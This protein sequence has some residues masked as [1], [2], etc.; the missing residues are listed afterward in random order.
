MN[1]NI[2]ILF[3]AVETG[4]LEQVRE[5]LDDPAFEVNINL[6]AFTLDQID[7]G[8]VLRQA[9][10]KGYNEIVK[11]LIQHDADVFIKDGFGWTVLHDAVHMNRFDVAKTLIDHGA[12]VNADLADPDVN[13]TPLMVAAGVIGE[14]PCQREMFELLTNAGA[15][16]DFVNQRGKTALHM[17]CRSA[18]TVAVQF[19]IGKGAA[20]TLKDRD[21][22][23]P[24]H[25]ACTNYNTATCRRWANRTD[26]DDT[27]HFWGYSEAD[28]S[29]DMTPI[30]GLLL[31]N[32][33][34][35]NATGHFFTTPL[36]LAIQSKNV[37]RVRLL[38]D[39]GADL[40]SR[41]G[42][43]NRNCLDGCD[44]NHCVPGCTSG[45]KLGESILE[46]A[47]NTTR[48]DMRPILDMIK[49]E[50]DRRRYENLLRSREAIMMGLHERLG[51]NSALCNLDPEL[52]RSLVDEILS[53]DS[54]SL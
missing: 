8:T 16:V 10:S 12:Y 51:E 20:L 49:N 28:N 14:L 34:D 50:P 24:I 38:L 6:S 3:A 35:V 4:N 1:N 27:M 39:R 32:G 37:F 21:R 9:C 11:L 45:R 26:I 18:H 13:E 53:L 19:L 17:A 42:S 25:Y 47:S 22:M 29:A 33:V 52:L 54:I 44:R 36:F 23:Q 2:N 48:G 15:V 40:Y 46:C 7:R 43:Y 30:I 5:I 31:D 41:I